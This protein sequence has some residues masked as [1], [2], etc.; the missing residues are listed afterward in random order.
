MSSASRRRRHSRSLFLPSS[1]AS[2]P[3]QA[4]L[5]NFWG[6]RILVRRG[7]V[8][9]RLDGYYPSSLARLIKIVIVFYL[10]FCIIFLKFYMLVMMS[11]S[12]DDDSAS[13]RC[14]LRMEKSVGESNNSLERSKEDLKPKYYMEFDSEIATFN[15]YNAYARSEGFSIRRDGHGKDKK[16]VLSSRTFV[17]C[18]DGFQK[19]DKRDD[20]TK[21]PRA[22][23]R[24]GCGAIM[25][26][27]LVRHTGK[28]CVYRFSE[29][30]NHPLVK[31]DCVQWLPSHRNVTSAD[32]AFID[33]TANSGLP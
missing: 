17:C 14:V 7:V 2:L 16:G 23:T 8:T 15:F 24:T 6:P 13:L 10:I 11:G 25:G 19:E 1:L 33:L 29:E 4:T 22:H 21:N 3:P 26:I 31:Q 5:V 12:A 27:K 20:L 18:K 28:Y 32:S 30:H 9:F